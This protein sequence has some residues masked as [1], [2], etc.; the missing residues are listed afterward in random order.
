MLVFAMKMSHA[1]RMD[2]RVLAVVAMG[3]RAERIGE[4]HCDAMWMTSIRR[5]H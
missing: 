2:W 1:E 4:V 3:G 5:G